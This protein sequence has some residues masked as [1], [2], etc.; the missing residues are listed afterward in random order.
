MELVMFPVL[1]LVST[2][3]LL[4]LHFII[5]TL[6]ERLFGSPNLPPGR[7]GWPLIGETP[8]FF[9][10]GF[11]AKPE[12]FIGER[13]EKYD[14]R[15]FKTSLLGKPFA[16]ISGTAG[17]KFLF[18]NENK[19]VNLWWPESVRMLFKSAL[20]S[21]V[22]DEAKRIRKMLMTFLG[23]DALKNY[24]ERI[25]MVTQ[26]HIRT[27]W[28]GKEEVT[29]YSTLKLYTFTLACNLFASIND[30]ERLSKLGAHFDV[31]VKGVI[32]L[33]ISIPGTRLYK[34]MK[35]ANAIRE[36]LKLIVRDRKEALERKMASP[37]QDL[38]SYLLVDSD[39]NGRFLSEME[40]LD[41]IMLLLYAGH[42]TSKSSLTLIMKYL[43]EMPDVYAKVLQ[44]QLEIAN[45]KKPGELLQWEDV[46][47]MR[48]SW[49][50]ISEVLR[51]SPPV[52]SAY[53]HA[54]VD[55]TYEGYT[56]P[57]GWQLFT[58]FGTTHRDPALFPNPERFDASRFEGNGP[59]SYSYIPFGG[60][61]RM[62][63]GYEFAR[64]EMLIF[65]HNIIKRFKWD[66]LI[67]DEHFG[68]DPLLAPSQGFPVRLR[69]HHSR[70]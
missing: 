43:A 16:V 28:E 46:Q 42:D 50:V 3:F 29:V 25:D 12:K 31:F 41:N 52:S 66:I 4:A 32:S 22:G 15:V 8:A 36:E 55:F 47:K 56:I 51:L 2:L 54:I 62:C 6:K 35:A 57:K 65:L 40:I 49:N 34:S 64:L 48:Y 59:P 24:T 11:E 33:P 58:S 17:H 53:R 61:P 27:Y 5:R 18:S 10:A 44:E 20:V 60:G 38:L 13:M 67:P 69:P 39:T 37:T 21:V 63:I 68:Y 30:P 23:L 9:R 19:L 70:L 26:Q 45:S 1:A 7:L 14:S